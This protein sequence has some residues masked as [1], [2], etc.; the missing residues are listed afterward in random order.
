MQTPSAR[1][2]TRSKQYSPV[3]EWLDRQPYE[4]VWRQMQVRAKAVANGKAEEIVWSCEHDPVYST[5]RRGVDNRLGEK[6]SAPF[7]TAD[8]GGETT[9]H[10]PGQIMLYPVIHLRGRGLGVKQYVCLLEQSCVDALASL[11]VQSRLRDGFPGVWTEQGKIA[12]LGVRIT[13]G[14]AYHGMAL[15]VS[16]EPLWFA[17]IKPC[18][19]GMPVTNVALFCTPPPLCD[20]AKI[21]YA[22]FCL[23][24]NV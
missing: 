1:T 9:F 16:V 13:H 6:L 14:V 5:G 22:H 8:R 24:M 10:G 12:A 3:F 21:W 20:L 2:R 17:A 15:N 18:G 4:P 23:R 7:I 19:I 11:G